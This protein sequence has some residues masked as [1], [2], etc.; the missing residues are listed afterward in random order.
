MHGL[1]GAACDLNDGPEASDPLAHRVF[2][3]FRRTAHLHKHVFMRR[4]A[5]KGTHPGQAMSLWMLAKHDGMTQRDLADLL[6]V[7]RPTVTV[8]LQKMEKAGLIERR[9][10]E[11]DQRYTRLHLTPA[12][13]RL[14]ERILT[15]HADIV[16]ATVARMT[17][18]DQRELERLLGILADNLASAM[19][20]PPAPA[21]H[22]HEPT[23]DRG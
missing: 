8:M 13:R 18:A 4:L 22:G 2:H 7:S 15:V 20:P 10:D 1:H 23:P 11:T 6:H 5:E 3:A 19:P 21:E 12:G 14:H 9:V 17:E 16:D